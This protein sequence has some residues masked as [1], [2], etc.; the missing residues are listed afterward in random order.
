MLLKVL[1]LALLVFVPQVALAEPEAG[2]PA[3][4]ETPPSAEEMQAGYESY[5]RDLIGENPYLEGRVELADGLA[6]LNLPSGYRFLPAA[7]ARRILV[8]LWQN[9]PEAAEDTLGMILPRGERLEDFESWAI[10]VEFT[11]DGYISD[12]DADEIDY[13]QLLKDMQQDA[14]E[15]NSTRLEQGYETI[16]IVRW[17]VEPRYDR[18][19]KVLFWAKELSFGGSPEHTLNYDVRVLGRR[20]TLNLQGVA[21]IGNLAEVEASTPEIVGMAEFLP[22]H[23]YADYDPATDKKSDL[24]LAGLVVGGAVAANIAAKAGLFTKIGLLLAKSWKLLLLGGVGV[25]AAV[26]KL[27]GNS[28]AA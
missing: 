27:R 22:G 9:P 13:S 7:E 21:G 24:S 23:R 10:V 1:P 16:E 25:A 20:G 6:A 2:D 19:R 26:K 3:T 15:A 5:I 12:H 28:P 4:A 11:P 17:A 14:R 18:D 8:D